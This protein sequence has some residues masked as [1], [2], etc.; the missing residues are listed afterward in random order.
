MDVTL[1]AVVAVVIKI[2]LIK[3]MGVSRK[4][5][6]VVPIRRVFCL[7]LF[8]TNANEPTLFSRISTSPSSATSSRPSCQMA[9]FC[10]RGGWPPT[11][12]SWVASTWRYAPG[13]CGWARRIR[14]LECASA[15]VILPWLQVDESE[16]RELFG[17]YGSVKEVK[18]ITYRGGICKGW[19]PP[20]LRA[21]ARVLNLSK[22][23][24]PFNG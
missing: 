21:K 22:V 7:Q 15:H 11:P 23:V 12:S 9:T 13:L 16:M 2:A 19:V 1:A 8:E 6:H 18:I 5:L 24:K 20:G 4:G 17:R 3:H 14:V 10:Q